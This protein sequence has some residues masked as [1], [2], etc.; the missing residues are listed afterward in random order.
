MHLG[1]PILEKGG[2]RWSAIVPFERVMVVSYRFS[3]V[4]IA[5]SLAIR[6]QFAIER[7]RCSKQQGALWHLGATFGE[8]ER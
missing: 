4:K 8:V 5:L 7:L 1:P 6:P 3:I 2:R